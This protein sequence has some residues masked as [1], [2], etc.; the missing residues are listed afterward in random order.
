[1]ITLRSPQAARFAALPR[2]A[3]RGF[4]GCRPP[5]RRGG[6]LALHHRTR[7]FTIGHAARELEWVARALS[8]LTLRRCPH[9]P[10]TTAGRG[11]ARPA[12]R[13]SDR[14]LSQPFPASSAWANH[15]LLGASP[16]RLA[17]PQPCAPLPNAWR[18]PAARGGRLVRADRRRAVGCNARIGQGSHSLVGPAT[19]ADFG[20]R[21]ERG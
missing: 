12:A 15:A 13:P 19:T 7:L 4:G 18:S 3:N 8:L 16:K 5:A 10:P 2:R 1:V 6:A 21:S 14:H 20:R 17:Q 11:R 9:V